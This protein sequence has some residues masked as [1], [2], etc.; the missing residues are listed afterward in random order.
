MHLRS[1]IN[2]LVLTTFVLAV[3]CAWA[4]DPREFDRMMA[5]P[6]AIP[7][8]CADLADLVNYSHDAS[9][10]EVNALM[11]YCDAQ[12]IAA[13]KKA[14]QDKLAQE[15]AAQKQLAKQKTSQRKPAPRKP[16]QRKAAAQNAA[17]PAAK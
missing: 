8:S 11:K 7:T 13:E 3:N 16:A 9:I 2:L 12:R 14:V 4:H 1:S 5:Q 10:Q 15:K 6:K 17:K